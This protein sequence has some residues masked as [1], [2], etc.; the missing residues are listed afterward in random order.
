MDYLAHMPR[1]SPLLLVSALMFAP[2]QAMAQATGMRFPD[3]TG[4]N[5]EGRQ[6]NLPA[7]FGSGRTIVLVAFRQRQQREVDTWMPELRSLRAAHSGLQV[8]EIPT[9]SSGWTPLRGWIDGGMARGIK[10][11]QVREVTVTLY[12][13]KGPFKEAL[14]ITSEGTI[15]LLLLD[16]EGRVTFRTTGPANAAGVAALRNALAP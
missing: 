5:L 8:Y 9:L 14:G 16:G 4:R 3:V 2:L 11:Q 13:R 1:L 10:D 7:D 15:H 12:I 6:L